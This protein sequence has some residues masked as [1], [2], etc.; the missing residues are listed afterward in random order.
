[1]NGE[2]VAD[3][4]SVMRTRTTAIVAGLLTLPVTHIL[5][6]VIGWQTIIWVGVTVALWPRGRLRRG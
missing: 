4:A 5:H 3:E 2:P 1:M 6:L